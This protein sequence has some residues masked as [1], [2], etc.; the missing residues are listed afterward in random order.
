MQLSF[1]KNNF[2][3]ELLN[4]LIKLL[5]ENK[6]FLEISTTL[7]SSSLF[8]E[9]ETIFNILLLL[10]FIK[11][12]NNNHQNENN[13]KYYLNNNFDELKMKLENYSENFECTKY[14]L[15]L[16]YKLIKYQD[17]QNDEIEK[18][19]KNQKFYISIYKFIIL[20]DKKLFYPEC[21]MKAYILLSD[22]LLYQYNNIEN[23]IS[24]LNLEFILNMKNFINLPTTIKYSLSLCLEK[25]LIYKKM[26]QISKETVDIINHNQIK[27]L[28]NYIQMLS[29]PW[30]NDLL[31]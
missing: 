30:N 27:L 26:N 19:Q 3:Q 8:E 11:N 5:I 18:I 10:Y 13:S 4:Y 12:F 7:S 21:T 31:R 14:E 24:K 22:M 6:S 15:N 16:I 1:I 23:N 9:I 29:E 2:Y 20:N 17:Y 28:L 25:I